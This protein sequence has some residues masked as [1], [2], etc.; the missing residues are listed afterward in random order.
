[1]LERRNVVDWNAIGAL[2]AS[3]TPAQR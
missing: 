3:L 2:V 1:L